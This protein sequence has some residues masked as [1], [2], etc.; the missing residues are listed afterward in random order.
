MAVSGRLSSMKLEIADQKAHMFVKITDQEFGGLK[1]VST[2]DETG[3]AEGGRFRLVSMTLPF[4][5]AHLHSQG[6]VLSVTDYSEDG[7]RIQPRPPDDVIASTPIGWRA[8][9]R[10]RKFFPLFHKRY[11]RPERPT[12]HRRLGGPERGIRPWTTADRG[13]LRRKPALLQA[14]AGW[15]ARRSSSVMICRLIKE[16]ADDRSDFEEGYGQAR[17]G[18]A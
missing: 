13:G 1:R 14:Y 7:R 17:R 5:R 10:A 3:L 2:A 16:P 15:I 12:G 4:C 18:A 8:A 11:R 9:S 6:G